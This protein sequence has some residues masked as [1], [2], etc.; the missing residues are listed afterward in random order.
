MVLGLVYTVVIP[1]LPLPTRFLFF[2]FMCVQLRKSNR[3]RLSF[4]SFFVRE[5]GVFFFLPWALVSCHATPSYFCS[6]S[7]SS[8]R[9]AVLMLT[10][11]FHKISSLIKRY[12]LT[13]FFL[14]FRHFPLSAC[15]FLSPRE[16]SSPSTPLLLHRTECVTLVPFFVLPSSYTPLTRLKTHPQFIFARDWLATNGLTF[17]FFFFFSF[18]FFFFF[19]FFLFRFRHPRGKLIFCVSLP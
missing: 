16:E 19:F 12:S 17:F 4:S 11:P 6:A 15:F 2:F 8:I 3:I 10:S 1:W 14:L 18:F 13:S 9:N 5:L 7:A